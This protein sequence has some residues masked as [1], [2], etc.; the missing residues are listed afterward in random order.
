MKRPVLLFLAAASV[1]AAAADYAAE[2]N[3]WWAHIQFLADD[4]RKICQFFLQESME[5]DASKH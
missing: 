1:L 4:L 5:S 2:G 3:L